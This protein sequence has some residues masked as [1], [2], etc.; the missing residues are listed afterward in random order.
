MG[1]FSSHS[2]TKVGIGGGEPSPWLNK[3]ERYTAVLQP[4]D[5]LLNPPFFWH[6]IDNRAAEKELV[7]GVPTRYAF[8]HSATAAWNSNPFFWFMTHATVI[9]KYG[10]IANYV[11]IVKEGGDLLEDKIEANRLQRGREMTEN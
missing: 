11:K 5:V 8:G 7:I 3:L 2:L 10:S 1:G 4:G 6:G 9:Y